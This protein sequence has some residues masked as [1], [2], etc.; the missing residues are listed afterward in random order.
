[1]KHPSHKAYLLLACFLL[2]LFSPGC[3]KSKKKPNIIL[4]M[5]D[6]LGY[7]GIGCYGNKEIKTPHLDA[8]AR[9]GIRFTDFHSNGSVCSPTRAALLTGKYQQRSGLEGVIYVRGE[10]R[11]VGLDTQHTTLAKVFQQNGYKTGIMGK[12]HLGYDQK[13]NPVQ[14]GFDEFYGYRSGNVD[15]HSHYDNAGTYDWYHNLDSL[16]EPGYVTDLITEH[17]IDFIKENKD[18]PFFLYVP[19]EAPHVPFQGRKDPGDRYPGADFE[20]WGS[21][22]DKERAYKE[23]VEVMD[24]GIGKTLKCLEE[25]GLSENTLI[26]FLSDNG[27]LRGFGDNGALRGFKTELYEGGHR[28]PAIA[29]WKGKIM[30]STV[31][32]LL[33]S[34]DLFPTFLSLCGINQPEGLGLEGQDFSSIFDEKDISTERDLFWK[35]RGQKSVRRDNWKLL[36]TKKDSALY[37]LSED[38]S[39]EAN[40]RN[41]NAN[42]YADLLDALTRWEKDIDRTPQ[43]TN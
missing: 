38:I 9:E 23:M 21:V 27:G 26:F 12:W 37:D 11:K 28:V 39:E 4:I 14:H 18:S 22:Q 2:A 3:Q 34:F 16:N 20:Y 29:Y 7:G 36:I 35:Y 19:H 5:A 25:Q 15:Y 43:V 13:Y 31:E 6:D 10:S 40:L 1:M 33:M 42:L 24:E 30:P 8:M 17:S 41:K 32:T